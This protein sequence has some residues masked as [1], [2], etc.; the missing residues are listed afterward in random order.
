[1]L[2]SFLLQVLNDVHNGNRASRNQAGQSEYNYKSVLPKNPIKFAK[3]VPAEDGL[4]D[5]G[6]DETEDRVKQS[7]YD[8]DDLLQQW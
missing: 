1:M 2:L 6:D 4:D 7:A 8:I 5:S 3:V